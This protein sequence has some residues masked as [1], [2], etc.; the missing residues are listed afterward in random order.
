MPYFKQCFI[1]FFLHILTSLVYQNT[2]IKYNELDSF[3]IAENNLAYFSKQE[4][5]LKT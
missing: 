4:F 5:K 3:H 2:E 1:H